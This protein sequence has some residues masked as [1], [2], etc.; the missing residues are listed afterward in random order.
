MVLNDVATIACDKLQDR[1]GGSEAQ[2]HQAQTG[3]E[4]QMLV[5]QSR[6]LL[7]KVIVTLCQ[8]QTVLLNLCN[9]MHL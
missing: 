5:D 4:Q 8:T 9:I 7:C 3:T 6:E 1:N 2:R